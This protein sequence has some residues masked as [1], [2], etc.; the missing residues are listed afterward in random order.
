MQA[1]ETKQGWWRAAALA[2]VWLWLFFDVIR[3]LIDDWRVD[4]NYSHGFLIPHHGHTLADMIRATTQDPPP[5]LRGLAPHVPRALADVIDILLQKR[6]ELRYADGDQVA[7]DLRLV[8]AMLAKQ[9]QTVRPTVEESATR[10]AAAA[11]SRGG[12]GPKAA[13]SPP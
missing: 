4:E 2:S 9:A 13:Q 11:K 3:R 7:V 1:W 6:P 12:Q 8:G 5:D 10:R